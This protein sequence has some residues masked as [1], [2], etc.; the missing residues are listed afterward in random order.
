MVSA[1]LMGGQRTFYCTLSWVHREKTARVTV[2]VHCKKAQPY[3]R[4]AWQVPY[5]QP[6]TKTLTKNTQGSERVKKRVELRMRPVGSLPS[7]LIL[8]FT[9][10]IWL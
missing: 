2:S 8:K 3:R 4:V 10:R 6:F 5:T 1:D 7:F 9:M